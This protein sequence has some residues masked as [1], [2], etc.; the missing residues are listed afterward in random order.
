[1]DRGLARRHRARV[2]RLVYTGAVTAA[3]QDL[4]PC[5]G[6]VG[7]TRSLPGK[8]CPLPWPK[9]WRAGVEGGPQDLDRTGVQGRLEGG[10]VLRLVPALPG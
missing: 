9:T 5:Q 2:Q 3:V 1:M 6:R 7:I 10:T 8:D 4:G